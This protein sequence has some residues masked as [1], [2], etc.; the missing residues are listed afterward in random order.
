MLQLSE[1]LLDHHLFEYSVSDIHG[2]DGV[3]GVILSSY[4]GQ[5]LHIRDMLLSC[6]AFNRYI[7]FAMLISAYSYY[8]RA[9]TVN[10]IVFN[11]VSNGKNI[12]S[13]K[14]FNLISNDISPVNLQAF[15]RPGIPSYAFSDQQ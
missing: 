9:N 3:V 14:F 8:D 11:H 13:D 6:R 15:H 12:A 2:D 7:E 10:A 1:L 4:D 5:S